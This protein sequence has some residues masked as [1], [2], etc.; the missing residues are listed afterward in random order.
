L[1]KI[2][3]RTEKGPVRA[4]NEDSYSI[5]ALESAAY[6]QD[7]AYLAVVCDGMGGENGGEVASMLAVEQI[8][9]TVRKSFRPDMGPNSVRDML[10]SAIV[11]ANSVIYAKAHED[12]DLY[13]MGTT[14]VACVVMGDTAYIANAGDSRAYYI[15]GG[16]IT[17]ITRDHTM[18]Q[19]YVEQG[20]ISPDE[21]KNHPQKHL[22]TRAL[23]VENEIQADYCE[24]SLAEGQKLV[25]CTDGLS[26]YVNAPSILEL[27]NRSRDESPVDALVDKA[28]QMGGSD[29]I[30][31]V[32]IDGEQAVEVRET[33]AS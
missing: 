30:T 10:V 1:I 27:V 23:G 25:I 29:N 2:T 12:S 8:T 14:V 9:Q 15:S 33:P 4:T 26:N 21:A 3:G 5:A 22:I 13:G 7:P 28:I 17:Q 6:V 16:S 11:S 20:K 24:Q 18:V 31:V 19:M 32:Y